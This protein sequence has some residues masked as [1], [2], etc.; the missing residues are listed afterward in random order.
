M[1]ISNISFT[2]FDMVEDNYNTR[3]LIQMVLFQASSC[4]YKYNWE[5]TCEHSFQT[6]SGLGWRSR[7]RDGLR[8]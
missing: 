7:D 4:K 5:N 8:C 2:L 1:A 3:I 6:A